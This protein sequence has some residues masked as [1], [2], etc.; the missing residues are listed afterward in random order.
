MSD[1]L[2]VV[3]DEPI[4][5]TLAGPRSVERG[6]VYL[7]EGRVGALRASATRVAAT[8]QGAESYAV[9]LSVD[10]GQLRFACSCPVGSDGAF[11]KHCVAVALRWLRD[12]GTTGP[13]L[14]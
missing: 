8:V 2:E 10:D 7:E 4:V 9:E 11:C 5:A 14:G 1:L 6:V 13:T 3:L 12:H